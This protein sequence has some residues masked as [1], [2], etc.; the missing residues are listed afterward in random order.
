MKAADFIIFLTSII[1]YQLLGVS[2]WLR[3]P[4]KSGIKSWDTWFFFRNFERLD[5]IEF[6]WWVAYDMFMNWNHLSFEKWRLSLFDELLFVTKNIKLINWICFRDLEGGVKL[7]KLCP[8]LFNHRFLSSH[9]ILI[10]ALLF[11][12]QLKRRH[13][14]LFS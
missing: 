6:T 7:V 8:V 14:L 1:F 12:W 2:G 5:L 10:Y 11:V 9:K 13:I 3:E 4:P